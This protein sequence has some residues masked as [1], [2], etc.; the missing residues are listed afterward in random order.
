MT[1]MADAAKAITNLCEIFE[2][3]GLGDPFGAGRAREAIL[4]NFLGHKLGDDLQGCDAT[5]DEG[6]LYEYKTVLADPEAPQASIREKI[7]GRYDVSDRPDW[8]TFVAYLKEEKIANNKCHYYAAFD[9]K[10]NLLSVYEMTGEVALDLLLPKLER[11]F[12][13]DKSELAS[14]VLHATLTAKDIRENSTRLL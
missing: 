12:F 10:M 8:D 3:L 14:P 5:D 2:T 13:Q 9:S 4:A 1:T 11:K 6:N 7:A